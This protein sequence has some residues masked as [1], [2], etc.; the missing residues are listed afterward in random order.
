LTIPQKPESKILITRKYLGVIFKEKQLS[1]GSKNLFPGA[2]NSIKI[3][4]AQ[5]LFPT[6]T[7]GSSFA[8]KPNP[9]FMGNIIILSVLALLLPLQAGIMARSF[10]RNFWRWFFITLPIPIIGNYILLCLGDRKETEPGENKD[11]QN[12]YVRRPIRLAANA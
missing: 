4:F 5:P 9:I 11:A 3:P 12:Q 7:P 1:P 6:L 10:G 8:V 2:A